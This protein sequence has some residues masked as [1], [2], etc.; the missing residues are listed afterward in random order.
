MPIVFFLINSI[1]ITGKT[2]RCIVHVS[3]SLQLSRV[4]S[5]VLAASFRE[6]AFH[7]LFFFVCQKKTK[8]MP[9][10]STDRSLP[11]AAKTLQAFAKPAVEGLVFVLPIVITT[12]RSAYFKFQ[13]LPQNALLF[14]YGAVFCFFGGTFPT[15]FAALQA[16]EHGGRKTVML[17]LND[18]ADEAMIIIQESK[19]DDTVDKDG[20]GRQDVDQLS[21]ASYVSRKTK[22]VLKKMNPEKIDKGLASMYGVWLSV[23]AV[24]SIQFARTISMALSIS[25]FMQRPVDRFI[26]P[27]LN[28][29]IPD[30]YEKWTPIVLSWAIKS[31]AVSIAWYIQSITSA[32]TS[33]L[34]GG[35]M[36]AQATYNFCIKH[37]MNLFGWIPDDHTESNVDEFLSYIFAFLGFTLYVVKPNSL[38][39]L[40]SNTSFVGL[41]VITSA[42]SCTTLRCHFLSPSFFGRSRLPNT[43]F[44]GRLQRSSSGNLPI[45]M[46][47]VV[48]PVFQ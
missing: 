38:K 39:T 44:V 37:E 40:D 27:T 15:L 31:I 20:D 7:F 35:L 46:C 41:L 9:S 33:A 24:L 29:A 3:V 4:G 16:A 2:R 18:L 47:G 1:T 21:H 5:F 30:E 34:A 26:A 14:I 23:A 43:G 6:I 12:L 13:K 48:G 28:V 22:L 36:M 11:A 17:A 45:R 10:K 19:K 25:N 8:T 32:F 42:N